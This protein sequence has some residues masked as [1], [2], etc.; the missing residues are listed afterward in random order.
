MGGGGTISVQGGLLMAG[1]EGLGGQVILAPMV[2]GDRLW[3]D[4]TIGS[5]TGL[6]NF[7]AGDLTVNYNI[8]ILNG[9]F[10]PGTTQITRSINS[11]PAR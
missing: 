3:G 10:V 5:I 4:R 11:V 6:S 8:N 9:G 7:T 2:R 1:K